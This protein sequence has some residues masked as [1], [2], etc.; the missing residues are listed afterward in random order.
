[1]ND[2]ERDPRFKFVM[3]FKNYGWSAGG[4]KIRHSRSQ[5][6]ATPVNPIRVKEELVGA[7]HY[8]DLHERCVYCDMVR[9]E[10]ESTERVVIENDHFVAIAP[11]A[12][13]FPFEI[14]I[15][16]K[17]HSCDFAK[18]AKG[19]VHDLS[20]ILKETL[21][22]LKIGL[23]DPA[24]N[25][26]IHTAP[27]RRPNPKGPQWKTIEEDYHWHIEVM[28]RLTHVA[29]FEKGTGF[30]ICAIPPENTAEFLREVEIDG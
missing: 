4:G 25:Y 9:Q 12:A 30:Y 3:A 13:R 15:L 5:L 22:R 7:K 10:C 17:K 23:N 1:M 18:G 26:V 21:L 27:F 16:P 14:W 8:F 19:L 6:I 11:F 24:Y 28:P 2:L 29:G 20:K